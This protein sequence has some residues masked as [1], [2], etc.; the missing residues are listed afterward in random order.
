M[1]TQ[2]QTQKLNTLVKEDVQ[3]PMVVREYP[4]SEETQAKVTEYC[5]SERYKA[6]LRKISELRGSITW[7]GDLDEMREGRFLDR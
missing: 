3:F 4:V 2:T 5:R 1:Q 6:A 7:E